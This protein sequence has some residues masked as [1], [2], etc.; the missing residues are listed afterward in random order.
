MVQGLEAGWQ[1]QEGRE[2]HERSHMLALFQRLA[3][4]MGGRTRKQIVLR[5]LL[6][7]T[8]AQL[9]QMARGLINSGLQ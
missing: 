9:G 3:A 7:A 4:C 2:G 8:G 5:D 6:S 1:A